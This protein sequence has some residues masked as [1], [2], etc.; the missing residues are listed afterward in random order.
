MDHPTVDVFNYDSIEDLEAT[1]RTVVQ[2]Q[3]EFNAA[4][5]ELLEQ[6]QRL[7]E[8]RHDPDALQDAA[9]YVNSHFGDDGGIASIAKQYAEEELKDPQEADNWE[10]LKDAVAAAEDNG[11]ELRDAHEQVWEEYGFTGGRYE[12]MVMD[13]VPFEHLMRV[14]EDRPHTL[15]Q[16][17]DRY[18]DRSRREEVGPTLVRLVDD[19]DRSRLTRKQADDHRRQTYLDRMTDE[20]TDRE[21]G[22]MHDLEYWQAQHIDERWADEHATTDPGRPA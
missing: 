18:E 3:K 11:T 16:D 21:P 12:Q 2:R 9:R 5:D 4:K 20:D 14:R 17:Q 6:V 13:Q 22:W 7:P 8:Y 15:F 10:E 1:I 19:P